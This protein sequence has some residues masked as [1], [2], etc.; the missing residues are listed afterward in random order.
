M[1]QVFRSI[2]EVSMDNESSKIDLIYFGSIVTKL[3]YTYPVNDDNINNF[4]KSFN[5]FKNPSYCKDVN[6]I[7][8]IYYYF[9][10]RDW[11]QE[12][13]NYYDGTSNTSILITHPYKFAQ[14][15][16][17]FGISICII[18]NDSISIVDNK[19]DNSVI[20][21]IDLNLTETMVAFDHF[22]KQLSGYFFIL[23]VKTDIPLYYPMVTKLNYFSNIERFEFDLNVTYFVDELLQFERIVKENFTNQMEEENTPDI[24]TNVNNSTYKNIYFKNGEQHNFTIYPLRLFIDPDDL[25]QPI[26]ILSVI[27]ISKDSI[28]VDSLKKSQIDL[29]PRLTIQIFLFVIMGAILMLVAWYLIISIAQNIIK[30]IKNLKNLIKGMNSEIKKFDQEDKT[31]ENEEEEE[32]V[33]EDTIDVRSVEIENLFNI[34]LKL[35][36]VLS[37]TSN[38]KVIHQNSALINYVNAKFTFQE[39]SNDRG[40]KLC[41]SNAGNLALKCNK[42]DK[43]ILH[44]LD[45]IPPIKEKDKSST[46]NYKSSDSENNNKNV[47]DSGSELKPLINNGNSKKTILLGI[48]FITIRK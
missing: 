10:C 26:H 1:I 12:T 11:Y 13:M 28:F 5:N 3:F 15:P 19:K 30:P 21:C 38:T 27:Y 45:A 48:L 22:N 16:S 29:I 43:A 18:F 34:L 39:V 37:F 44:L 33:D 47:E 25:N 36:H 42:Y 40:K 32:E 14:K 41:D 20:F 7:T 24:I 46:N 35:K 9:E 2:F 23:R 17:G 8:P 31:T 4:Y 6:G